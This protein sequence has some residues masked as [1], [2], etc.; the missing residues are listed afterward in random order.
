MV[1]A[2]RRFLAAFPDPRRLRRR[3]AR[4]RSSGPGRASAT[5]GGRATCTG[6]RPS[7]WPSTPAGCPATSAPCCACP[8]SGPT[9]PGPCWPSPSRRTWGWWTPTPAECSRG[10]SPVGRSAPGR[11][12]I[13]WTPWSRP[14]AAGSSARPCS[15]WGRWSAWPGPRVAATARSAAAAGGRPGEATFPIPPRARPA[16]RLPR[17]SSTGSDRQGRGRLIDA[18]RAGAVRA[19]RVAAAAGWPDDPERAGRVAAGLVAEGLVARDG[20]GTLRLP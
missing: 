6:R 15:T 7:S 17:A 2:Y 1:P 19:D 5:T 20:A 9:R 8:A 3:P 14:E 18:L 10:R 11:H 13:W 16:S 12:R 4:V